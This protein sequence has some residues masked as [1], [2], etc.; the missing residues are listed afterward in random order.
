MVT[1]GSVVKGEGVWSDWLCIVIVDLWGLRKGRGR[2]QC[3]GVV[4][5]DSG[6]QLLKTG[7]V[8]EQLHK[9]SDGSAEERGIYYV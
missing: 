7:P 4:M 2:G 3:I 1:V 9:F 6:E 8:R 5:L